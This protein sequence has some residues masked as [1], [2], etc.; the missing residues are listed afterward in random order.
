MD[1][2][3][4]TFEHNIP[5]VNILIMKLLEHYMECHREG[6]QYRTALTLLPPQFQVQFAQLFHA[7]KEQCQ[8]Q[9]SEFFQDVQDSLAK[10]HDVQAPLEMFLSRLQ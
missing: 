2:P 3:L 4:N 7:A 10:G 9:A 1:K 8:Q 6:L 5:A